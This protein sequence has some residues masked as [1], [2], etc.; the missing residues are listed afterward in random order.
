MALI[1]SLKNFFGLGKATRR[2]RH[3]SYQA[4]PVGNRALP[5][6]MQKEV[7]AAAQ[8]KRERKE[9]A[10]IHTHHVQRKQGNHIFD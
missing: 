5:H 3:Q 1:K 4:T 8:A 7:M 2:R 10:H 9:R 6:A